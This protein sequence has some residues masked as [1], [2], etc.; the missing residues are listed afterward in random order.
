MPERPGLIGQADGG[1]LFL[2]EIAELPQEQQAHLL[3]VLDAGEYQRLGDAAVRRSSFRL[4][5]AT[6]RDPSVLK[7]DLR[8]RFTCVVQLTPLAARREDIPL[9]ARHL[10]LGAVRRSP[11]VAG[12]FVA[13]AGSGGEVVRFSPRFIE[14]ALR[15]PLTANTRDL[16]GALWRAMS[17]ST[18]DEIESPSDWR[19]ESVLSRPSAQPEL[20]PQSGSS[21]EE[22]RAPRPV[23]PEPS[24]E[25][26]RG[27]LAAMGGSVGKAARVLG[28][29]SRFTLYRL[30]KKHGIG[31]S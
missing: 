28:L 4:L 7:H 24:P 16:D 17:E 9:L 31:E 29:S 14:A 12:R 20:R 25:D 6:N 21:P 27:A 19:V 18:G 8:A 22:V 30:M 23:I 10:V 15:Q 2:D 26:I 1:T 13:R 5:G 3:R 11:D